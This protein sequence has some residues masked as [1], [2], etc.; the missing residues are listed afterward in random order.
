MPLQDARPYD[1]R[2][3]HQPRILDHSP[4]FNALLDT[5]YTDL[6]TPSDDR[7]SL[8]GVSRKLVSAVARSCSIKEALTNPKAKAALDKEWDRLRSIHT[9]DENKVREWSE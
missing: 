8:D 5:V 4:C 3:V 7:R 9:W 6:Y 1:E 2:H